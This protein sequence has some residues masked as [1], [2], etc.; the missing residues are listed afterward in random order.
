M[1]HIKKKKKS[2]KKKTLKNKFLHLI[3]LHKRLQYR[4]WAEEESTE[5][6]VID[7]ICSSGSTSDDNKKG[8]TFSEAW[9]LLKSFALLNAFISSILNFKNENVNL[10]SKRLVWF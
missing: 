8:Y 9:I 2:K 5:V 4:S 6:K 3:S 10:V 7:V 1:V